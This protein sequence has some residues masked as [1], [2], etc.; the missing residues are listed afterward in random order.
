[1]AVCSA[2]LEPWYWRAPDRGCSQARARR[3]IPS[4]SPAGRKRVGKRLQVVVVH[5]GNRPHRQVTVCPVP[6]MKAT[7][8]SRIATSRVLNSRPDENVNNVQP[9][10]ID[11]YC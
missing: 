9:S 8:G 1:M 3:R 10:F 4:R 6:F 2:T 5:V 11:E 7:H